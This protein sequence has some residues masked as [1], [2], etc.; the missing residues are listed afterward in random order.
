MTEAITPAA[1]RRLPEQGRHL[2]RIV[3]VTLG[4]HVG[5]N[6]ARASIHG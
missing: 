1:C 5:C 4:Q 3:G 2:G 6:L